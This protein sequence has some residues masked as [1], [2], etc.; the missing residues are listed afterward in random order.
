[1]KFNGNDGYVNDALGADKGADVAAAFTHFTFD[2]TDGD[3]MCADIQGVGLEWTD[4]QLHSKVREYGPGDLGGEGMKLFFESHVCN[5]MCNML[6]LPSTSK[7]LQLIAATCDAA[8]S[9]ELHA[10]LK[11]HV[12]KEC[13]ICMDAPR[14]AVCKPCLHLT[15]C[16]DCAKLAACNSHC[17]V[18]RVEVESVVIVGSRVAARR[19]TYLA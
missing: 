8:G 9:A 18:C 19:S 1:M 2:Q 7:S 6:Q 5:K 11:K 13:V 4:P 12:S 14:A 15:F 3:E 16:R 17:P 10:M